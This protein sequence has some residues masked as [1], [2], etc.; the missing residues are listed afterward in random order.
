MEKGKI[1]TSGDWPR[2]NAR[3]SLPVPQGVA[4]GTVLQG[5]TYQD[6]EIIEWRLLRLTTAMFAVI[7]GGT[8]RTGGWH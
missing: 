8:L 6:R 4:Q 7:R 2:A 1:T 3:A 5:I